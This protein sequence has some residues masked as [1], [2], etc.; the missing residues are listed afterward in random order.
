M[1]QGSI[2]K[3]AALLAD[4]RRNRAP[5]ERLPDDCRPASIGEALAIQEALVEALGERI[6]GYK[7]ARLPGGDLA[8]GVIVGSRIIASGG[9]VDAC[10]M[11]L[12]G[13]EA[14]IAFRFLRDMPPRASDYLYDEVAEHVVAFPALEIVATR[15]R[16]YQQTPVIERAADF[17]SNGAF[18]VGAD[19]PRWR[20]L[21]LVDL[22]VA[23]AFDDEIVAERVGGH[24]ARDP[25]VP[26]VDLAAA[27]RTRDGLRA[28]EVVTTGTYTGLHFARPGQRV[29][30]R[31]E[32]FA[33]VMV[34]VR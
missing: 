29:T 23:L 10:D 16:D 14:E 22:R 7:V 6:A 8:W 17:M 25:L 28:G 18:V 19:Q 31:F 5:L 3:A 15:Y 9:R 34:T 30:A 21:D 32:G 1:D 24:A 2:V 12:L 26:A 20:S 13:M 11:P 4:A 27:F 33:P